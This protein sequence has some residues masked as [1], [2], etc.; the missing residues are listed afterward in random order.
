MYIFISIKI[1]L[2]FLRKIESTVFT[3][4]DKLNFKVITK[5][6]YNAVKGEKMNFR[7]VKNF[8]DKIVALG[9]KPRM[10]VRP[11]SYTPLVMVI[12]PKMVK[13]LIR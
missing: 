7:K 6:I 13:Y 5:N 1:N 12:L 10:G 3:S 4:A 2:S 11:W 9:Q 8:F